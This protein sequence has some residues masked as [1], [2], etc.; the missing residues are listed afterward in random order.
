MAILPNDQFYTNDSF[1]EIE[2][3]FLSNLYYAYLLAKKWK[4]SRYVDAFSLE[5]EKEIMTLFYLLKNN[6]WK[7]WNYTAFIIQDPVCREIFAAPFHDR[8]IHHLVHQYLTPVMDPRM[9]FDSYGAR[10]GKWIHRWVKRVSHFLRSY[11]QQHTEAWI[12]KIDIKNFFHSINHLVLLDKIKDIL[13]KHPSPCPLGDDWLY[14]VIES[15]ITHDPRNQVVVQGNKNDWAKLP[16]H[17]SLFFTKDDTWL[18]LWHLTSQLFANRYLTSLDHFTKHDLWAKYYWRYM[19]D[20]IL[21]YHDK[22]TLIDRNGKI[23]NFLKEKLFLTLHPNKFYL[24]ESK[25]WVVFIWYRIHERWIVLWP[26]IIKNWHA[27]IRK[28]NYII[29]DRKGYVDIVKIRDCMNTYF[30]RAQH[31]KNLHLR[32]KMY[33]LLHPKIQNELIPRSWYFSLRLRKKVIT[34]KGMKSIK[35]YY[36]ELFI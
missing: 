32:K 25:K 13:E 34:W 29:R 26:R 5:R 11:K 1:S 19:D 31:W 35:Y 6:E 2:K 7:P 16:K 17:K 22:L 12:M 18:P 23:E 15:I 36:P 33:Y 8:I 20:M 14:T 30:W 9:V 21:I 3:E 27:K 28:W 4:K 10:I 24:Q